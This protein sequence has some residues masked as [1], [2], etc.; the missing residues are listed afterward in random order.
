MKTFYLH[1]FENSK[2]QRQY[3]RHMGFTAKISQTDRL[4]VVNVQ[5]AMCSKK[6]NYSRKTGREVCETK[7]VIE[8]HLKD[9]G[10]FLQ[11][12]HDAIFFGDFASEGKH[13]EFDWV[14]AK[15]LD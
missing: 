15:L 14:V 9:L 1:C 2:L 10:A 3:C 12:T 13:S 8:V 11:K 4:H 5:I 6:D 7:P